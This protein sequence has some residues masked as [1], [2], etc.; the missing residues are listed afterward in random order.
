M[1]NGNSQ[2]RRGWGRGWGSGPKVTN[3]NS[4]ARR[5]WGHGWGSGPKVTNRNSQARRGLG[6]G[7]GSGP[8]VTNEYKNFEP[9]YYLKW[10]LP[11]MKPLK[12]VE[13]RKAPFLTLTF[14]QKLTTKEL[15]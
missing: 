14:M 12:G 4:Q 3:R 1:T 9:P 15:S 11:L 7:W 13:Y 8:K 5:G 2:A 10:R 6:R